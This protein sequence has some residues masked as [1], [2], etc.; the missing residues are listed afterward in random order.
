MRTLAEGGAMARLVEEVVDGEVFTVRRLS[1]GDHE[2]A[3][4]DFTWH[5]L[6]WDAADDDFDSFAVGCQVLY[7]D[8]FD[9]GESWYQVVDANGDGA[10]EWHRVE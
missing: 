8:D 2:Q 4:N 1:E 10:G 7:R 5:R 3:V 6:G 9:T